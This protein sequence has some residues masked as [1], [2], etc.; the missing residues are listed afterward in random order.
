MLVRGCGEVGSAWKLAFKHKRARQ[1]KALRLPDPLLNSSL[2]LEICTA[3]GKL[4]VDHECKRKFSIPSVR[5]YGYGELGAARR[6]LETAL[7][8]RVPLRNYGLPG[9][10][11]AF[12]EYGSDLGS[13]RGLEVAGSVRSDGSS[14][15][16][17]A[18]VSSAEWETKRGAS[19]DACT[20]QLFLDHVPLL[21]Y[22]LS[23]IRLPYLM[24]II[25]HP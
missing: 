16:A 20:R 10:A 17:A 25:P 2:S 7:E 9:I 6:F 8:A 13:A 14:V 21:F 18:D 15:A 24:W 12:T 5:G 3:T 22:Q 23:V 4:S 19:W 1:W 11:Y